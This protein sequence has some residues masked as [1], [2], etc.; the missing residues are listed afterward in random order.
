MSN[1]GGKRE[2]AGRPSG[3]GEFG[4]PTV[5]IRIPQ[6]QGSYIKNYLDAYSAKEQAQIMRQPTWMRF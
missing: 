6:S 5:S 4:E 3:Q 2:N 1:R